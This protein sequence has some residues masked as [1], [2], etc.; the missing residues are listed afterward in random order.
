MQVRHGFTAVVT[1]VNHEPVAGFFQAQF[2]RH[3]GGFKQQVAEQ[4]L[5]VGLG[6]GDARDQFFGDNQNVR[7]RLRADVAEG[8]DGIVFVN[9]VRRDFARDDFF[10]KSF[11]SIFI[12]SLKLKQSALTSSFRTKN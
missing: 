11:Q 2:F 3:F 5:V 1:I 12:L 4:V 6:F 7:R 9:D 10:K 8:E